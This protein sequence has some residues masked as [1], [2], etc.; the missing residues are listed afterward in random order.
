MVIFDRI[1]ANACKTIEVH[2]KPAQPKVVAQDAPQVEVEAPKPDGQTGAKRNR[3]K[4]D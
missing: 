2:N 4:E 3:K 1:V